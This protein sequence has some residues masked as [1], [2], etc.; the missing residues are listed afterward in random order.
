MHCK[1]SESIMYCIQAK[2][3]SGITLCKRRLSLFC[4]P[5]KALALSRFHCPVYSNFNAHS[6]DIAVAFLAVTL[7]WEQLG[8]HLLNPYILYLN[9][10]PYLFYRCPYDAWYCWRSHSGTLLEYCSFEKTGYRADASNC[11]R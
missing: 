4:I 10:Y 2:C 11:I 1:V 5:I 6:K 8:P 7:C 9:P 3:L